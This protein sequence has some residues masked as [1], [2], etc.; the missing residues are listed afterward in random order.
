[1]EII[2]FEQNQTPEILVCDIFQKLTDVKI[3]RS[4]FNKNVSRDATM[5]NYPYLVYKHW[6][7]PKNLIIDFWLTQ[8]DIDKRPTLTLEERNLI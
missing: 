4:K 2:L 5:G 8:T 3:H 6:F 1:M 7:I